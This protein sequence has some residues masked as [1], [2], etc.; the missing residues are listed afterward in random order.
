MLSFDAVFIAQPSTCILTPS[1]VSNANSTTMFSYYFQQSFYTLFT[2]LS[3]FKT[4]TLS[5]AKFLFQTIQLGVACLC[6]VLTLIYIIIYYVAKS[7][8]SK[9]I[10][11]SQQQQQQRDY[12]A[13]Q[14]SYPYQQQ[15]QPPQG[16]AYYRQPQAPRAPQA[17]PGEVPWNSY[18]KY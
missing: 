11:P 16:N 3:T 13:P 9:R 12:Y 17:P 18:R 1:C 6:F 10:S 2:N 5:Q 14:P 4:Y 7:K 8:A 15:Q